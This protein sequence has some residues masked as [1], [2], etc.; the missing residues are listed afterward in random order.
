M[1]TTAL[2]GLEKAIITS[3]CTKKALIPT[4]IY[5]QTSAQLSALLREAVLTPRRR[6]M[7][8]SKISE[9]NAATNPTMNQASVLPSIA[10]SSSN[11]PMK[12]RRMTVRQ[13][14]IES[15]PPIVS[16]SFRF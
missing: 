13:E 5:R 2:K 7:T 3:E 12:K 8:P 9:R 11:G 15:L 14:P 10:L 4:Q 16:E 1:P 6:A